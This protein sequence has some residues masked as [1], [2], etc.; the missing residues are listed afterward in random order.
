MRK[1]ST[2]LFDYIN[3]I[4]TWKCERGFDY[5]AMADRNGRVRLFEAFFMQIEACYVELDA[6]ILAMK[7]DLVARSLI[8]VTENGEILSIPQLLPSGDV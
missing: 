8:V 4:A 1:L 2:T 3:F 7:Y 6:K 5:I